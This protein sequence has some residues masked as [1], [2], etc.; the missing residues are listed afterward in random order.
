VFGVSVVEVSVQLDVAVVVR[1][2]VVVVVVM[3][4][5]VVVVILVVAVV[6]LI[7]KAMYSPM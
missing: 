2:G 7:G 5:A 4:G 6:E 3:V 1:V